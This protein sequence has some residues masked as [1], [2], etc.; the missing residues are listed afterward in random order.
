MDDTYPDDRQDATDRART[1][2]ELGGDPDD[3]GVDPWDLH[4]PVERDESE[5]WV[6]E[7]FRVE[8]AGTEAA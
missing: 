4:T 7:C 5:P 8:S 1:V 3:L 2:A 6:Q